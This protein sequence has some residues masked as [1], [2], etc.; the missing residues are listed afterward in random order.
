MQ[1]EIVKYETAK[2]AKEKG[3]NIYQE[4]QYSQ[5]TINKTILRNYSLSQCKLYNDMFYAPSQSLL[6]KWLRDNDLFIKVS[7]ITYSE[8]FTIKYSV[9]IISLEE[10]LYTLGERIYHGFDLFKTYE[11]ALE[12]GLIQGLKLIK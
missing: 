4:Q 8:D 6:Q 12:E 1:E 7:V 9:D 11:E 2:L 5:D 10:N 3:F